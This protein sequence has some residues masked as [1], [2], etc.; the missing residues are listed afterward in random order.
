VELIKIEVSGARDDKFRGACDGREERSTQGGEPQMR[1][2][3]KSFEYIDHPT[4]A[5]DSGTR[6]SHQETPG[7]FANSTTERLENFIVDETRGSTSLGAS[8]SSLCT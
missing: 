5:S 3:S 7:T 4:F 1:K 8:Y 2:T 6:F